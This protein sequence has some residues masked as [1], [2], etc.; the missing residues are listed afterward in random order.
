MAEWFLMGR[1]HNTPVLRVS[2]PATRIFDGEISHHLRKTSTH[3]QLVCVTVAMI[4]NGHN[5]Q[6]GEDLQNTAPVF[7]RPGG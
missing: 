2:F 1:G 3:P 5:P 4:C 7:V 6:Q